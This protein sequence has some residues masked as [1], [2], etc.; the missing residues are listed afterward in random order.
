MRMTTSLLAQT[1]PTVAR[2]PLRVT[3]SGLAIRPRLRFTL[4]IPGGYQHIS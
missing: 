2:E 3:C 1:K 4:G